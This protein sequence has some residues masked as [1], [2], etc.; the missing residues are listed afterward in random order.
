MRH[1]RL[2]LFTPRATQQRPHDRFLLQV[3]RLRFSFFIYGDMPS[4]R[5]AGF[6]GR[7]QLFSLATPRH[8]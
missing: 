6:R 5:H 8:S 2:P 4:C 1:Y 7:A 3:T